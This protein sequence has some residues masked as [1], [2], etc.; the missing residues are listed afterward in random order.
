VTT[1]SLHQGGETKTFVRDRDLSSDRLERELT[2]AAL[3]VTFNGQRFDVPFLETCFDVD[4]DVPHVDLM[5]PCKSWGSTA[6]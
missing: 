6:D 1:V 2:D 3:L 5:Y 4:I